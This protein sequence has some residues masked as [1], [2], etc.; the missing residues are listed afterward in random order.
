MKKK[1]S[2]LL[3]GVLF[4]S[5]IFACFNTPKLNAQENKGYENFLKQPGLYSKIINF[6]RQ[7]SQ[8]KKNLDFEIKNFIILNTFDLLLSFFC[9]WLAFLLFFGK[10]KIWEKNYLWFLFIVNLSWFLFLIFLRLAWR[11]MDFLVIRLESDLRTVFLDNFYLLAI[12]GGLCIYI[13]LQARSFQLVFF[14]TVKIFLVSHLFYF[15]VISFFLLSI[16]A[17]ENAFFDLIKM[18]FGIESIIQNYIS[19]VDKVTSGQDVLSFIRLR[20]FH[21]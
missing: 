3:L 8:V 18:R 21:I 20:A 4:F 2:Y 10:R 12:S 7:E 11:G 1:I 6:L 9:L 15:L 14:D 5:F 17:R 16:G 13:W 19:D